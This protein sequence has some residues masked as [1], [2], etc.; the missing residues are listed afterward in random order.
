MTR[1]TSVKQMFRKIWQ[2]QEL[3]KLLSMNSSI[4]RMHSFE[5]EG[6]E[7][8]IARKTHRKCTTPIGYRNV[9]CFLFLSEWHLKNFGSLL[10]LLRTPNFGIMVPL[11]VDEGDWLR[12]FVGTNGANVSSQDLEFTHNLTWAPTLILFGYHQDRV[13]FITMNPILTKWQH[14]DIRLESVNPFLLVT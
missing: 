4:M 13:T 6:G 1:T 8:Q 14:Q 3:Y 5:Y 11:P 2:I 10:N 9:Y 12:T 7:T